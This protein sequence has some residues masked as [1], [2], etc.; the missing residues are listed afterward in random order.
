MVFVTDVPIFACSPRR[1]TIEMLSTS[2]PEGYT[3]KSLRIEEKFLRK[4]HIYMKSLK[5]Y[6]N[7]QTRK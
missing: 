2:I 4:N 5:L 1:P 3:I 6:Y 7:I